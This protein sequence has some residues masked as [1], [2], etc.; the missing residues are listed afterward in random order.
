MSR[1]AF[2]PIQ[3]YKFIKFVYTNRNFIL[4]IANTKKGRLDNWAYF[5]CNKYKDYP[6]K[7]IEL[8]KHQGSFRDHHIAI[9]HNVNT[10][11]LRIFSATLDDVMFFS[12]I[13]FCD[14]LYHFVINT[15][16]KDLNPQSF[17]NYVK[18]NKLRYPNLFYRLEKYKLS[19]EEKKQKQYIYKNKVED[20]AVNNVINNVVNHVA[21]NIAGNVAGSVVGS[22]VGNVANNRIENGATPRMYAPRLNIE[23]LT[24]TPIVQPLPPRE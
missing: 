17:I 1:K 12:Y 4:F 14:S 13:Q 9:A 18:S 5:E 24:R 7:V 15:H 11:E 16:L 21:N 19:P 2:T 8:I 23:D 3:L 22:V 20:R 10:I 6:K